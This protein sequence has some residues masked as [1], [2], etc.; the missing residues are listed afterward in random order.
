MFFYGAHKNARF[1]NGKR[2]F[3]IICFKRL[4]IL[5]LQSRY[6]YGQRCLWPVEF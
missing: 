3:F 2:A 6:G 1:A 4:A 5:A